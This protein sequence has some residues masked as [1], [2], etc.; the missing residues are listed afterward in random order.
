[1][2]RSVILLPGEE[3]VLCMGRAARRAPGVRNLGSERQLVRALVQVHGF[4]VLNSRG[5]AM[6]AGCAGPGPLHG[7]P[8]A[9]LWRK[10]NFCNES[11]ARL[12][13]AAAAAGK[14]L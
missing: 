12:E 10:Q 11:P 7:L 14:R 5:Q 13:N 3:G 2:T 6:G 4:T 1:M 8:A 9:A